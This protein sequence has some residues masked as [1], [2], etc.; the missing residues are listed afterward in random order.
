MAHGPVPIMGEPG[1]QGILPGEV[2][3]IDNSSATQAQP[4][5]IRP[6]PSVT[7]S[8]IN[9]VRPPI[10]ITAAAAPAAAGTTPRTQTPGSDSMT[11]PTGANQPAQEQKAPRRGII[12]SFVDRIARRSGSKN[13]QPAKS[14]GAKSGPVNDPTSA[15]EDR[16]VSTGDAASAT[17]P[18]AAPVA[19]SLG[20]QGRRDPMVSQASWEANSS[21]AVRPGDG[22]LPQSSGGLRREASNQNLANGPPA[23]NT[24]SVAVTTS[25]SAGIPREVPGPDWFT[26]SA[27]NSAQGSER[28]GVR[29]PAASP[30]GGSTP[31]NSQHPAR[32]E[33]RPPAQSA[34]RSTRCGT[35]VDL[36]DELPGR[37]CI[38]SLAERKGWSR[39]VRIRLSAR[40]A[41]RQ[42]GLPQ[43]VR[44]FFPATH[45]HAQ[46][47][48]QYPAAKPTLPHRPAGRDAREHRS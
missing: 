26:G 41:A 43:S 19:S 25:E 15:P 31:A 6:D 28:P 13:A 8:S 12:R 36:D 7:E 22:G 29:S 10:A 32:T 34:R 11:S 16:A 18:V 44:C 3:P 21:F 35:D 48:Q 27:L 46:A 17:L 4:G 5:S 39:H 33:P 42:A 40:R 24:L 37:A 38:A 20:R 30:D 47:R 23:G 45:K 9:G 14:S 2:A 1:A